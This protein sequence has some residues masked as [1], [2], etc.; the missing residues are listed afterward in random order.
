MSKDGGLCRDPEC[1]VDQEMALGREGSA[2]DLV[3]GDDPLAR[4][5]EQLLVTPVRVLPSQLLC[6]QIVVA[7]PEQ[8]QRLQ[9]GLAVPS[10]RPEGCIRRGDTGEDVSGCGTQGSATSQTPVRPPTSRGRPNP[11]APLRGAAASPYSPWGPSCPVAGS[12]AAH[13]SRGACAPRGK[14]G[15]G[16]D[17]SCP[18]EKLR[19]ASLQECEEP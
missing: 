2:T 7:E 6:H 8:A 1:P 3:S 19:S 4:V 9:E 15:S 17:A 10:L 12:G 11:P 13:M 16:P 18:P 5:L 14:A